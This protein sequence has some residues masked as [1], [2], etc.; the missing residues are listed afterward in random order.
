VQVVSQVAIE[1]IVLMVY[2]VAGGATIGVLASK[3]FIPFFQAA[4]KN[5]L[6][7]PMMIP[8]IAWQDIGRISGAFTIVLVFAQIVVIS[9]ALRKGVFQALRMGDQE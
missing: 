7:P 1:Y 5:V 4:D 2:S 9:A 6:R 8:L 3:L